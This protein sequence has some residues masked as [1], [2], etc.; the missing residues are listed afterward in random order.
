LALAHRF[1][2][3]FH[4]STFK[5]T[6]TPPPAR[7]GTEPIGEFLLAQHNGHCEYFAAAMTLMCQMS[8][9]PARV[10]CG[11]SGGDYNAVGHFFIVRKKHAHAWVEAYIPGL[12]WVTF[13]PTP[14]RNDDMA[15]KSRRM[16]L[17]L[18]KYFDYFQFL[19]ANLVI[20]YD[21]DLRRS[22][23]NRFS[24]WLLR[25]VQDEATV[26]GAVA[27]FVRELFGWRLQLNWRERFI[28][29][30]FTLLI[31]T[32][33]V[34]VGYVLYRLFVWLFSRLR[35]M[36]PERAHSAGNVHAEFY[37]RFC[38]Q[39]RSWGIT[40]RPNQ[41]PA[42]FARELTKLSF[43]APAAALVQAYYQVAFG[44][45]PLSPAQQVEI[46]GFLSQLATADTN[47]IRAEWASLG[48]F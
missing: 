15:G 30:L 31:V 38:R 48:Y 28:Y 16:F 10:I 4:S 35:K 44:G 13:D 26:L 17:G 24:T 2:E 34:L 27:A 5:Y 43:C 23:F 22:L 42:E 39:L 12:D 37:R 46:D 36:W 18:S 8:G 20:S 11:Y 45:V 21:A 3:Y 29:W 1:E 9:I 7:P 40:R 25:P 47:Q 6:L 33:A 14:P 32:L 41:T 19:W